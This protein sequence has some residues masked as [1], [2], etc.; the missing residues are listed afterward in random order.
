MRGLDTHYHIRGGLP[1][2]PFLGGLISRWAEGRPSRAG[3]HH[4]RAHGPPKTECRRRLTSASCILHS[5]AS[6]GPPSRRPWVFIFP[7]QRPVKMSP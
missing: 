5:Y 7:C 3:F 6:A 4:L 1:G 2:P